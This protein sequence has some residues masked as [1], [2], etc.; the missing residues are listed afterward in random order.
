[1]N[2]K[3]MKKQIFSVLLAGVVTLGFTSCAAPSTDNTSAPSGTNESSKAN[4]VKDNG[5]P[6]ELKMLSLPSN[7]SGLIEGWWANELKKS[8][9][10]TIDLLPSGDQGEQKLQ[11]LMASGELP[12]LVVFKDYKQVE[13]AVVGDMLLAY[14]DYKDLLPDVYANAENALKYAADNL[15]NG[16]GKA[17]T[18]GTSVKNTM[19]IRGNKEPWLRYDL[20]KQ[21]GSPKINDLHDYLPVLKKM[22]ELEPKNAD[23]QKVYG[24]SIWK[25]WDR[26]Y[27]AMV[28]FAG[29][30]SGVEYAGEGALAEIDHANNRKIS[31]IVDEDSFYLEFVNFCYKANQMGL[32]DPD[33]MTQ[34]FDDAIG[35]V[36]SG[37][38]LMA[39]GD[40]GTGDFGTTEVQNKGIGFMPVFTENNP[41]V[42]EG[43]EPV[44]RTWTISVGKSTKNPEAAMK[45]VNHF[46]SFDG[47]M[48][49]AN[50]PKGVMWD[51]DENKKPFITKEGYEYMNNPDKELPGGKSFG[52][53]YLITA[54]GLNGT[55]IHPE[56]G[57]PIGNAY[58]EK[59]DYAPADTKLKDMWQ[60][61]YKAEDSV[62]YL[63]K[64]GDKNGLV[65]FP[66]IAQ[67]IYTDEIEQISS[68]V[69]DVIKTISWKM[70]Y[71]KNDA[72]YESLKK[73]MIEKSEGMGINKFV[74]WYTAEYTKALEFGAKYVD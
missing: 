10:V 31:S 2:F 21:L 20:Y 3:M 67:P 70:V 55:T 53:G 59:P 54:V 46:F 29:K 64:R 40:W 42:T 4:D 6:V 38:V 18:V 48:L 71:A 36:G 35:K 39:L 14:D 11:A 41:T 44:G 16:Q 13:N 30:F 63:T 69:G 9:N 24:L 50:G 43:I 28:G 27:M 74:D 66:F 52:K 34:R 19:E 56:Y 68:R 62:D 1:M 49:Q 65:P 33:S 60:E 22:Q 12:D 32:L 26:A 23:G 8:I 17:F 5:K 47:A 7:T 51:V 45:F 25:D 57:V 72:E 15:S 37:R 58:W 73:E 61:D